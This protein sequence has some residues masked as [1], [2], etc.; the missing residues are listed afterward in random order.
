MKQPTL[1]DIASRANKSQMILSLTLAQA[2][3]E[4]EQAREAGDELGAQIMEELI[5]TLIAQLTPIEE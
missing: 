4:L 3:E 5:H 1:Y 2:M